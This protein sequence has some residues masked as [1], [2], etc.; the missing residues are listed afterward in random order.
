MECQG[1]KK[2]LSITA[3][4]IRTFALPLALAL[5][6]CSP[7]IPGAL[8]AKRLQE[9]STQPGTT[10]PVDQS[11]LHGTLTQEFSSRHHPS[12]EFFPALG[13]DV[14]WRPTREPEFEPIRNARFSWLSTPGCFDLY[15]RPPPA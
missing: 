12:D 10:A 4:L 3:G 2:L 7:T 6:V 15:Q 8:D 14:F 11:Q 13:G 1:S 5:A 9:P